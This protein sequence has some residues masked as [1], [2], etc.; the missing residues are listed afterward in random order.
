MWIGRLQQVQSK[1]LKEKLDWQ[2]LLP[3][4]VKLK[5]LPL[6]ESIIRSKTCV[7]FVALD[8]TGGVQREII[9]WFYES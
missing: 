8:A 3:L 1:Q 4:L 9:N 5:T 6:P 2:M 7:C